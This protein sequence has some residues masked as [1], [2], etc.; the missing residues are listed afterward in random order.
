MEQLGKRERQIMDVLYRLGRATA[1]D[2]R[3]GLEEPPTYSAVRGMLRFLEEKGLV[4]HEQDGVRYVYVPTVEPKKARKSALKHVVH[5][6]FRGSA[7]EAAAALIE[8]GKMS[9]DELDT[10]TALL[11][12]ARKE[13]R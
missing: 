7:R 12:K 1:A 3:G 5:T 10:L 2:V 6:F 11:E 9:G 4:R 8:D 13:G